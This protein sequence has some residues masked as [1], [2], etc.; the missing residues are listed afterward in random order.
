M[1]QR[2]K[3]VVPTNYLSRNGYQVVF[4]AQQRPPA[5]TPEI[6]HRFFFPKTFKQTVMVSKKG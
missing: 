5:L 1:K 6:N 4:G 3:K 2:L